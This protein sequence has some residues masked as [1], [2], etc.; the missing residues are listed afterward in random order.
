MQQA[1]P[2]MQ[3]RGGSSKG[4]YFSAADLPLDNSRRDSVLLAAMGGSDPRQ[5]DGLGGGHPLTSKAAIV[6]RSERSDADLDYLFLQVVV[7][8]G[9][10]DTTPSCGN[11]LAGVVPFAI[12]SGL[13][14]AAAGTTTAVVHMLNSGRLCEVSVETPGGRV[15]YA[16]NTRIDGVPGTSAPVRCNYLETA[17]SIC[18]AL[19]PTGNAWDCVDG[20][21]VTCI[22]N[23]MPV[24]ILRAGDVGLSGTE[25][26]AE[27]NADRTLKAR[28]E[29][30]RL[31]VGPA[32]NLGD[33]ADR[34]VPKMCLVS[35][36]RN[37]GCI[38]TRTFIP[39]VCHGA[40]GVLGAVS[41]ATACV[42]EGSV[43]DGIARVNRDN[44]EQFSIEHPAGEFTV[45]LELE[46]RDGMPL[47]KRAGLLRTARLL[48][49]GELYVQTG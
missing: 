41:V 12:E 5:I 43:T 46:I 10:V 3:Y 11:I 31:A 8:E 37:Q 9:R 28:L 20:I 47:V 7:G 18:G 15:S 26:P 30:I 24:V 35:P 19:L 1:L 21:A 33:V 39:H 45:S 6:G 2:Y 34:V 38:C 22:D 48:S 32:M 4:L 23:G 13:H 44:P 40:I 17:G 49:R 42:L 25:T 36:P 29:S 16:G 27:L 14:A